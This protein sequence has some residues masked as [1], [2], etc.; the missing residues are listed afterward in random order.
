[1]FWLTCKFAH[2]CL[3][4]DQIVFAE[5][6]VVSFF[7]GILDTSEN[8]QCFGLLQYERSLLSVGQSLSFQ[9]VHLTIQEFLAALYLVTLHNEEKVK[10]CEAHARSDQFAM[11][12]RCVFGLGCK[13]EGSYSKKVIHLDDKVVNRFLKVTEVFKQYLLLCHCLPESLNDTVGSK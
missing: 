9:F 4:H 1:M 6:E 3:L 2:E 10:I 5:S 7:P 11:F 12:R 8:L 13:K